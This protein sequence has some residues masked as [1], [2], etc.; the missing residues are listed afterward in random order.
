[1]EGDEE[2]NEDRELEKIETRDKEGEREVE[3]E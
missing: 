1:M 3:R 2:G